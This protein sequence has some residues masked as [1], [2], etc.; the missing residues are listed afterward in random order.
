MLK[1]FYDGQTM[2]NYEI[3]KAVGVDKKTIYRIETNRRLDVRLLFEIAKV[4]KMSP[5]TLGKK[6]IEQW[7]NQETE[8]KINSM[9]R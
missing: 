3:A 5:T 8:E 7:D 2:S 1:K 9:E 6:I 4:L